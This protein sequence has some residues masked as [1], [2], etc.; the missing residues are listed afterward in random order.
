MTGQLT[1]ADG[2]ATPPPAII[3][4]S[5]DA[6]AF[7]YR[8][9]FHDGDLWDFSVS[10]NKLAQALSL[11]TMQEALDLIVNALP[12]EGRLVDEADVARIELLPWGA[13]LRR[14]EAC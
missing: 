7:L 3:P 8:I 1:T 4:I 9:H 12:S 2:G 6:P 11:A 5:A 14:M 13:G 10:L